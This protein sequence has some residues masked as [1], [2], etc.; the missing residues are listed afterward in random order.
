ME[1][2]HQQPVPVSTQ[3]PIQIRLSADADALLVKRARELNMRKTQL[4]RLLVEEGLVRFS[5]SQIV[6]IE[7]RIKRA[8]LAERERRR[9]AA[10]VTSQAKS[11]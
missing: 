11:L 1:S 3:P 8:A 10:F 7:Y 6:A 2:V 4:M 9:K 5:D